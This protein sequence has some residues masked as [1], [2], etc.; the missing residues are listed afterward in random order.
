MWGRG[1]VGLAGTTFDKLPNWMPMINF[2]VGMLN[3]SPIF[4]AKYRREKIDVTA[5]DNV[6]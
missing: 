3:S 6:F 1:M 5:S 4:D 2:W